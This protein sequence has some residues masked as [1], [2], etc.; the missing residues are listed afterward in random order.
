MTNSKLKVC[1]AFFDKQIHL[2][3]MLSVIYYGLGQTLNP[4]ELLTGCHV[5]IMISNH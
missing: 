1:P 2:L 3:W 4:P 5:S